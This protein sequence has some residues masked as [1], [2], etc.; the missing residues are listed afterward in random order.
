MTSQDYMRAIIT[1]GITALLLVAMLAPA[2][3]IVMSEFR[4]LKLVVAAIARKH[5][6]TF[7]DL[8]DITHLKKGVH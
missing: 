7:D 8:E 6:I 5:H 2:L 1:A 4:M 3:R